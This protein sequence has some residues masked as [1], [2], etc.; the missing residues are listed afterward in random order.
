MRLQLIK[1]DK[2]EGNVDSL[3]NRI[4]NVRTWSYVSNKKNWIENQ[5]YWIEKT[6]L[7]EDKL[8][9]RLHEEL[10]KTFIDKRASVLARGLKQ[11]MKFKTEIF[12]NNDIKIDDQFIGKIKGLKLELDLKKGSLETDIKS[13][14]KAARQTIGPELEKRIQNIIDTGLVELSNDFKIYW[15]KFVIAKLMPGN[16][17]LNPNFELIVDDMLEQN[18]RKKLY[19]FLDKFIKN[20]VNTIL[21]SLIDLK[22][23]KDKNSSIKALAYQLY[24]NNGVLKRENVS[25]YLKVLGQNERKILRDLGVKFGRYHVFLYKLIKPE[26]VLLRTLLWKNFHQKY[27]NLTPPTFGL[28]FI[29]DKDNRNK[30]FMLLCG[31]EKFDNYFVRIDI[32]ERLFKQIINSNS[33]ENKEIKLVSEML[34]LLGCSKDNFKKLIQKMNYKIYEK[35]EDLYFRYMP[36][37]NFKKTDKKKPVKE[38]PFRILKNLE[39]S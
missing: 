11:D 12:E 29:E 23:L 2:L 31:F 28:N 5:D 16:D 21:E 38:N 39:L 9:D 8:S 10:T 37:K 18:Q 32:L 6:K 25:E 7:L 4:A 17:Y 34:N 15:N 13:L 27:F 36:K 14:K 30:N 24:E 20:K 26:P 33:D 3:S 19:E 1:L 22:N 35:K